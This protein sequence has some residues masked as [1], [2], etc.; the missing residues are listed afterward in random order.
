MIQQPT[1]VWMQPKPFLMIIEW[2]KIGKDRK[3]ASEIILPIP[4]AVPVSHN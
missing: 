4:A 1:P 3:I 2:I